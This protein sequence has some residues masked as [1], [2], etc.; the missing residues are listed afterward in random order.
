MKRTCIVDTNAGVVIN[1]V[2]YDEIPEGNP[3]G[4][5][6]GNIAVASDIAQIGWTWDGTSL[7]SPPIDEAAAIAAYK[8]T[9][10]NALNKT[11]AVAI[12]CFKAG[13]SFN[14]EWVSY[15]QALR[16]IVSSPTVDPN[17]PLPPQPPYPNGS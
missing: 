9:A 4:F 7:S 16:A 1:V 17:A 12:R 8:I 6:E 10:Q 14:A 2:D 11:D 13:V 15:T 5:D 3:P